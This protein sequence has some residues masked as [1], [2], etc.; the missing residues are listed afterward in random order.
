M[1]VFI[2]EWPRRLPLHSFDVFILLE[3]FEHVRYFFSLIILDSLPSIRLFR[4]KF[5]PFERYLRKFFLC[6]WVLSAHFF[7]ILPV[8]FHN[9]TVR[10]SYV[11]IYSVSVQQNVV[12]SAYFTIWVYLLVFYI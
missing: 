9:K 3:F 10:V 2:R 8:E 7:E 6:Q 5:F 12:S 1:V 4:C 11:I